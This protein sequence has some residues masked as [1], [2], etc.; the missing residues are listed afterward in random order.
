M[1]FYTGV[2]SRNTPKNIQEVMVALAYKLS[3]KKYILRSG[4]AEGADYAFEYGC[5]NAN[6]NM[7]I[8]LPW[9]GFNNLYN[10]L[11]H[12]LLNNFNNIEQ[13]T[14]IAK[15]YH[16]NFDKLSPGAQ[17]LMT[18]NSYQVLGQ[19]LNTMSEFLVCWTPDACTSM[20]DRTQK[21]GGTG[22]AIA[23]AS[24]YGLP[25]FNLALKEHRERI[26]AFVK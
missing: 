17:K 11:E 14:I 21:T 10:D 13:A 4:G 15:T 26:L 2:G 6:S 7:E 23:I 5:R 1:K 19:D 25:I 20:E 9:D 18:R 3:K 22:Q 12:F 24:D 16:P 8:F